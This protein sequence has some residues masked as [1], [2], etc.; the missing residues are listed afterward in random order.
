MDFPSIG[1]NSITSVDR[2]G[3]DLNTGK[4]RDSVQLELDMVGVSILQSVQTTDQIKQ[5]ELQGGKVDIS[6]QHL[7]KMIE[8]AVKAVQGHSTSLDISVH[9]QTKQLMVKVVE[10]DTGKV[11]R[12]VPPEKSLDFV[13]SIWKTIG[14]I[15]DEKG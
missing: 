9:K 15:V 6:D 3:N 12:E 5:L 11:I 14:I 1:A 4:T 7:I 10:R 2:Q 13:A 8:K